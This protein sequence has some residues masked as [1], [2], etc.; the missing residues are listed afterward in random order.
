M[1]L[2]DFGCGFVVFLIN[3]RHRETTFFPLPRY[4]ETAISL[5]FTGSRNSPH[6]SGEL[7]NRNS[8]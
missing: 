1:L 2:F 5:R 3:H 4:K 6:D 7:A 8:L